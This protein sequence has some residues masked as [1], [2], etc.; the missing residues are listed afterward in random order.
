MEMPGLRLSAVNSTVCRVRTKIGN[1]KQRRGKYKI[2]SSHQ[3]YLLTSVSILIFPCKSGFRANCNVNSPFQWYAF[4][5]Y[6]FKTV[7]KKPGQ[8]ESGDYE[9]LKQ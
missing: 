4:I 7:K 8:L 3:M 6:S 5:S 1:E 9:L 2:F